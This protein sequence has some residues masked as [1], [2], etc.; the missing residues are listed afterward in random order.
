MDPENKNQNPKKEE[1]TR[2][3]CDPAHAPAPSLGVCKS[4]HWREVRLNNVCSLYHILVIR[5]FAIYYCKSITNLNGKFWATEVQH[6]LAPF[7]IM[8]LILTHFASS[9]IPGD[10]TL[11][12][13]NHLHSTQYVQNK[14][15][16]LNPGA[17][18]F[19]FFFMIHYFSFSLFQASSI[20]PW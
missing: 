8:S 17:A 15:L 3:W 16:E 18:W 7:S 5:S 19:Q 13:T 4:R 9:G 12:L 20:K 2:W 11:H 10:V 1:A 6:L 14:I